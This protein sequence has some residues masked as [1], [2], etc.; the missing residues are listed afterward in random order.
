MYSIFS[1]Y[2]ISEFLS[3]IVGFLQYQK[4][5]LLVKPIFYFKTGR[6]NFTVNINSKVKLLILK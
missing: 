2:I 6:K 4:C 5:T 1:N 3:L